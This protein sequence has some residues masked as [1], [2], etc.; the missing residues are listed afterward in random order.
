MISMLSTQCNFCGQTG[1][2]VCPGNINESIFYHEANGEYFVSQYRTK[3]GKLVIKELKSQY[4][5]GVLRPIF[6]KIIMT[7]P[8]Y[9]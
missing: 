9:E 5:D 6:E 1:I 7:K 4:E 3:S 8:E 2:H